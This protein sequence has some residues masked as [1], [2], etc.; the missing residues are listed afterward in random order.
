M[1]SPQ[2]DDLCLLLAA[3]TTASLSGCVQALAGRTVVRPAPR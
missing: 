2:K 3:L 1:L